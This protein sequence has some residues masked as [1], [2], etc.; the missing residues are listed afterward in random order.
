MTNKKNS[1]K[2]NP[3]KFNLSLSVPGLIFSSVFLLLVL[4]WAFILGVIVGRGYHPQSIMNSGERRTTSQKQGNKTLSSRENKVLKP[5]ELG[6]YDSLQEKAESD[7]ASEK[8]STRVAKEKQS[9]RNDVSGSR[10]ESLGS[11]EK[12]P[13]KFVYTYQVGAFREKSTAD[14]LRRKINRAG[15]DTIL[16]K[17]HKDNKIW[18]RTF[19][20]FK[21]S[22]K[23]TRLFKERLAHLGF[24]NFFLHKKEPLG[25]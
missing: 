1:T 13:R 22:P 7:S 17:V 5:E 14:R 4:V 16:K 3:K 6:F 20:T 19:V 8:D 23:D 12:R 9:A 10:K 11:K 2:K 24:E 25:R 21:G 15:F 18:Y